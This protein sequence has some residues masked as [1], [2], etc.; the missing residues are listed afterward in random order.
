MSTLPIPLFAFGFASPWMLGGLALG[1]IPIIIHLLH[2]RR[3]RETYWAAM[4]FLLE[5][6]RKNTRR[7]RVEQ[8]ILLVVRTLILLFLVLALAQPYVETLGTYF[9]ADAPTHRIIVVDT[10]FSMRFQPAEFSQ[11]DRAKQMAQ[12]IVAGAKRGDAFNLDIPEAKVCEKMGI[13]MIDNL[14]EKVQSSRWIL[15]ELKE[16]LEAAKEGYLHKK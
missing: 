16:N 9:Q 3:Y 12:K 15:S 8:L 2:K 7:L 14:G 1:S 6:A 13:E 4:R 11:F 10:S 5:A